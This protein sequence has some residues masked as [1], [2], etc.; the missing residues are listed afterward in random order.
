[1]SGEATGARS[2]DLASSVAQRREE[3]VLAREEVAR[4]AAMD[5]GYLDCS[6]RNHAAALGSGMLLRV[7]RALETTPTST[8]GGDVGR[9]RRARPIRTRC[10]QP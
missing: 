6:E 2:G 8:A 7:A 3:L 10:W 9:P 4:P 1:M 5:A